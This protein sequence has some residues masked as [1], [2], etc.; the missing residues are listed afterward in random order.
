MVLKMLKGLKRLVLTTGLL[1]GVGLFLCATDVKAEPAPGLTFT[2]NSSDNGF[3]VELETDGTETE[4]ASKL[5]FSDANNTVLFEHDVN[6]PTSATSKYE[7]YSFS[8]LD[9][10]KEVREKTLALDGAHQDNIHVSLKV[11]N[12]K[13]YESNCASKEIYKI[14][15]PTQNTDIFA[16]INY[17]IEVG[18]SGGKRTYSNTGYGYSGE[19]YSIKSVGN[20]SY[21]EKF[22][23]DATPDWW[24]MTTVAGSDTNILSGT[25]GGSDV[26]GGNAYYVP[27]IRG[28]SITDTGIVGTNCKIIDDKV[29]LNDN[30]TEKEKKITVNVKLN[31]LSGETKDDTMLAGLA[32]LEI[33]PLLANYTRNIDDTK[34]FI[35]SN[36]APSITFKKL[37]ESSED[38]SIK[39]HFTVAHGTDEYT[40]QNIEPETIK[41]LTIYAAPESLKTYNA[42][43]TQLVTNVTVNKNST[44]DVIIDVAP[45]GAFQIVLD[46]NNTG[47]TYSISDK[48]KAEVKNYETIKITG[49]NGTGNEEVELNVTIN[50]TSPTLPGYPLSTTLKVKVLEIDSANTKKEINSKGYDFITIGDSFSL[51][52]KKIL[53]SCARNSSDGKVNDA[54]LT[55]IKVKDN[56]SAVSVDS[57]SFKL[58]GKQV[59]KVKLDA[60]YNGNSTTGKADVEDLEI[61]VYPMPTLSYNTSART[62]DAIIPV[63]VATSYNDSNKLTPATGF[64]ITLEDSS[65]TVLYEYADSKYSGVTTPSSTDYSFKKTLSA[66]EVEAMVTSAA[67]NGKFSSD[68]T[69]VKFR[70]V[71]MNKS[72]NKADSRV[73]STASTT[74]YR[75]TASG[76]NFATTYAYGLDGQSVSLVASPLSGYTFARWSDNGTDSTKNPRTVTVNGSGTRTFTAVTTSSTSSSSSSTTNRTGGTGSGD[77]SDLYDNVPRTAESNSAIWLIVFMVFAVMGTA[78]ALYLQLKAATSKN[79]K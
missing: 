13:N 8:D 56:S 69:D 17:S 67:S 38:G 79:D 16:T 49:L 53:E 64:K 37:A 12:S 34:N 50:P 71:P 11:A 27:I 63:K 45:A 78:Y 20:T 23:T 42:S 35:A 48:I 66:S 2:R 43:G 76:T 6:I 46:E 41:E 10:L 4:T 75:V 68:K 77:D 18:P 15:K 70:I 19:D 36:T 33:K 14:T 57:S 72:G 51:D 21:Y 65:G 40:K 30:G 29:F 74:V 73:N 24:E 25:L 60:F 1:C 22:Y 47:F 31:S 52:L 26:T 5:V 62:L 9:F 55:G 7:I 3:V 58:I 28:I 39:L 61:T 44:T 59:G 54:I 32:G